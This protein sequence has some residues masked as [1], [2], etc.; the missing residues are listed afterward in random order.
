MRAGT[1]SSRAACATAAPWLPPDAATTP[2]A[3]TERRSRLANAPR[4]LKEPDCCSSSSL[5]TSV[6]PPRPKSR[7]STSTTGVRRMY[8]RITGSVAAI[9]S[10]PTLE[11]VTEHPACLGDALLVAAVEGPLLDPLRPD[12]PEARECFEVT[13]RARLRHP[14]LVGDEDA[15]D[16]VP[17][18]VAVDLRR[19][20]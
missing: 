8:G 13:V 1:F 7:P 17:H 9:C 11:G 3:G 18:Q 16:A 20:V 10:R 2:T 12:E 5:S 6:T 4:A 15:A 19:E 14:Q